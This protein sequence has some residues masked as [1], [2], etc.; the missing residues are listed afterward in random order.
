MTHLLDTGWIIR[1]LRGAREYTAVISRL[2]SK[3]L[4]IST[5]TLAELAEGICHASDPN[6]AR[7][8]VGLRIVSD[9]NAS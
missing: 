3:E 9:P 6:L 8:V 1:H 2:G 5:V 4:A 7:K